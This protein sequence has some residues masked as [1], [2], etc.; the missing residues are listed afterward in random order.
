MQDLT[1]KKKETLATIQ[2]K[3]EDEKK[4]EIEEGEFK[5]QLITPEKKK[6][7]INKKFLSPRLIEYLAIVKE[8]KTE[9][10]PSDFWVF[11][12]Q[13]RLS[14]KVESKVPGRKLKVM[15]TN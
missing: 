3:L 5:F 10:N 13:A 2:K 11:V 1:S 14:K 7:T 4:I 15:K 9:F 12:E 8:K 6:P